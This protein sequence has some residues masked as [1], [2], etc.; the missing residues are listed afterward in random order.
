[1]MN[2]SSKKFALETVEDREGVCSTY[3]KILVRRA[4]EDF[5]G[6]VHTIGGDGPGLS[7]S[8]FL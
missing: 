6:R 2:R 1:M 3:N 8:I 4:I 7:T 5:D